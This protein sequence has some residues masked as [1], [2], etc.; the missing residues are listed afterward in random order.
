MKAEKRGIKKDRAR[1]R[2]KEGF[3][4]TRSLRSLES[5]EDTEEEGYFFLVS[6]GS[7]LSVVKNLSSF[8]GNKG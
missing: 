8:F 1:A 5:T 7:V 6:V 3:F 4:T 2:K